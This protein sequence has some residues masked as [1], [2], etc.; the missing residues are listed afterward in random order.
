MRPAYSSAGW[1]LPWALAN[2]WIWEAYGD[3]HRLVSGLTTAITKACDLRYLCKRQDAAQRH[4][5]GR[6][7]SAAGSGR[8]GQRMHNLLRFGCLRCDEPRRPDRFKIARESPL[9]WRTI[10]EQPEVE[11]PLRISRRMWLHA[12]DLRDF[13]FGLEQWC[14]DGA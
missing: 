11:E 4:L 5:G 2:L 3:T 6:A 7:G 8:K 1:R 14:H 10:L 12:T 13:T 9:L